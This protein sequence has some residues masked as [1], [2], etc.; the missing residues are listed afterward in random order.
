MSTISEP[1]S[2]KLM[3]EFYSLSACNKDER[4]SAVN[5]FTALPE[6]DDQKQYVVDRL[7]A[8]LAS[9]RAGSRYGYST[10]LTLFEIA[11]DKLDLDSKTDASKNAIGYHLLCTSCYFSGQYSEDT[12][13]LLQKQLKLVSQHTYLKAAVV[14]SIVNLC[15]DEVE[16]RDADEFF[17]EHVL[18][19]ISPGLSKSFDKMSP[20]EFLLLVGLKDKFSKILRKQLN[21]PVKKGH[22]VIQGSDF[23]ALIELLKA[24]DKCLKIPLILAI[25]QLGRENEA[26]P[27]YYEE[28]VEPYLL[29]GDE[30]KAI[31]RYFE[32][33][34]QLLAVAN[35]SKCAKILLEELCT[36]FN[37]VLVKNMRKYSHRADPSILIIY[38]GVHLLIGSLLTAFEECIGEAKANGKLDQASLQ[39]LL[40]LLDD[41]ENGDFDT[42]VGCQVKFG[43]FLVSQLDADSLNQFVDKAFLQGPWSLRR[44]E[45]NAFRSQNVET[46][47]SILTKIVQRDT[48]ASLFNT[49]CNLVDQCFV[50]K[51]RRFQ[52]MGVV[53]SEDDIETFKQVAANLRSSNKSKPIEPDMRPLQTLSF[54][55][56]ILSAA[57][58][59]REEKDQYLADAK[60]ASHCSRKFDSGIFVDLLLSVLIRKNRAHKAIVYY[61]F[62]AFALKLSCENV[63]LVV[64][65]IAKTDNQLSGEDEEGDDDEFQPITQEELDDLK[66]SKQVKGSSEETVVKEGSDEDTESDES[67]EETDDTDEEDDTEQKV[68]PKLVHDVKK[69]LGKSA[70]LDGNENDDDEEMS[71]SEMQRLDDALA[72]AFRR[73]SSKEKRLHKEELRVFRNKCFDLLNIF[74][75]V[76]N[77]DVITSLSEN[78]KQLDEK[79]TKDGVKDFQQKIRHV[80]LILADR[81]KKSRKDGGMKR[82]LEEE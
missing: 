50:V 30:S 34:N 40:Y 8:G 31:N 10:A 53:V 19:T 78:L 27:Q 11:D 14:E 77:V 33:L 12:E 28:I 68:N 63:R 48:S 4:L 18:P 56:R 41:T 7:I 32:V 76:A 75:S 72:D 65:T 66:N 35:A 13:K 61:A 20:E 80:Q 70:F 16:G 22:L 73:N 81:A 25:F 79:F 26:F 62:S 5:R 9:S 37:E 6:L 2:Q 23:P 39:K 71:E 74:F 3:E 1:A 60:E 43:E 57:C 46:K 82:K 58:P 47:V 29:H 59:E 36:M 69:A 45:H 52:F 49:V 17:R 21:V 24:A 51:F 67:D 42:K 44:I 54:I 55:L 64:E 15:N 38:R